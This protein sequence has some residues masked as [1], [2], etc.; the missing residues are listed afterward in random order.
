M[1]KKNWAYLLFIFALILFAFTRL[2]SKGD[3]GDKIN[4]SLV[5][6]HAPAGWGYDVYANDSVYIH[7]EY[8]PAIEGRKGFHSEE[9]ANTI[10]RLVISKMKYG[11][12]PVISL[13]EL[14]SCEIRR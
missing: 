7:Q 5:T 9:E 10:G 2:K 13:L 14:D 11:K 6:F 8:I 1:I 4:I 3:H 12:F